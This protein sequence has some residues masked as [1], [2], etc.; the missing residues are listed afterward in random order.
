MSW[1]S[2]AG[3]AQNACTRNPALLPAACSLREGFYCSVST[4]LRASGGAAQGAYQ[5]NGR[6]QACLC[7][8]T[9]S[10]IL[11]IQG[12]L[13]PS[14]S[15]DWLTGPLIIKGYSSPDSF[16]KRPS[17]QIAQVFSMLL[18]T[19]ALR[20]S[21]SQGTPASPRWLPRFLLPPFHSS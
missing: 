6:T 18:P 13:R 11:W 16:R 5:G 20:A 9:P 4:C 8:A 1:L 3:S 10:V 17:V 2:L 21:T 7:R 19:S 14:V 12:P 15:S